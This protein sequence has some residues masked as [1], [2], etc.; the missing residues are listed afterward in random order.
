ME[1]SEEQKLFVETAQAGKNILVD[2][3]IGS[4]KTTAIQELCNVL[5]PYKKILYLTYNR[6]LKLDA[7]SKIRAANTMVQNYHGFAA[8]MLYRNH[9]QAAGQSDLIQAFLRMRPQIP[10]FDV[11]II[12]EYQDIEQEL[13]ELLWRI[14]ERNPLIQI[15]AVGDMQQK[16]YDKT[17]LNVPAFMHDFLGAHETLNFTRCFRL[18]KDH[19]AMLGRIWEKDIVGVNQNCTIEY[20]SV[21]DVVHFLVN[22]NAKDILCLGSRTNGDMVRV[23]NYL[24]EKCPERFNKNTVY[25]SIQDVDVA[26]KKTTPDTSCAIF[27]TFDS[28]KG[29]ERPI[30]VVFDFTEDYWGVRLRQ[31]QASYEILRNVFCVAASRGKQEIIFVQG[32]TATL[33]EET[34]SE[35]TKPNEHF[36]PVAISEMFDFKYREDIEECYRLVQQKDVSPSDRSVIEVDSTDGLIDLSPCIGEYQEFSFFTH[37]SVDDVLKETLTMAGSSHLYTEELEAKSQEEKIL[38]LTA[39]ETKQ[40]RY[41]RQV[42]VPYVMEHEKEALQ[43]RLAT[44]FNPDEENIQ[45]PCE[46]PFAKEMGGSRSFTAMGRADVVLDDTVW[47]MKFVSEL[48]HEHVLQ[49]AMYMIALNLPKGMLWNIRDNHLIEISIPDRKKLMDAVAR[50]VTKHA[51][52]AYY[53]PK[54]LSDADV[55]PTADEPKTAQTKTE[56]GWIINGVEDVQ[57]KPQQQAGR[58]KAQSKSQKQM[59]LSEISDPGEYFAVVDTEANFQNELMSVGMLIVQKKD[60]AVKEEYYAMITPACNKAAMYSS[61]L[62]YQSEVGE[63]WNQLITNEKAAMRAILKVLQERHI[64]VVFAFSAGFDQKMLPVLHDFI[65]CDIMDIALYKQ[66]NSRLPVKASFYGTGRLKRGGSVEGLLRM[67]DNPRYQETHNALQDAKDELRIMELIGKPVEEYFV[68][69]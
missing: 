34:L 49:C 65:W 43:K 31:P 20:M 36:K 64:R 41:V 6:L 55:M 17:T 4:G 1:L 8:S 19:A 12:D 58:S 44:R 3:C 42:S 50:T 33:S 60:L 54:D 25:A 28:S 23:L 59:S 13:S 66:H 15:I 38:F 67:M 9:M 48:S 69:A 56:D 46:I 52:A 7:Q 35:N 22:Q 18:S 39:F 61:S 40:Q 14:K 16:I 47:E 37:Y 68:K 24:E 5:P 26:G 53:L 29:L 30:C 27:T 62:K 21:R 11:L 57:S 51:Y 2:A 63:H 32:D 45:C 10:I